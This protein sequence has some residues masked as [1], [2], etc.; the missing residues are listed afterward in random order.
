M[1]NGPKKSFSGGPKSSPA[2]SPNATKGC[3]KGSSGDKGRATPPQVDR[4]Y[5]PK[6]NP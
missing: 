2:C 3:F 5:K 4:R 1:K 6:G